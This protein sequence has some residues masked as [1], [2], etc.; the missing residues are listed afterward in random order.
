VLS[1]FSSREYRLLWAG[2]AI[3]FLGDQF[4]LVALPWLVL[5]LTRDPLQLGLVLACS[6]ILR[7]AF[8][9][10]G[11][12]WAD[13]HSPR[14]IMLISDAVR[15]LVAMLLFVTIMTGTIELWMIYVVA[16][17]FGT[18]SGFFHPAA[19]AAIPRLLDSKRLESGNS[20]FQLA[21]QVAAFLGP[22]AAGVLIAYFGGAAVGGEEVAS[23]RGIGVAFALDGAS[24]ALSAACLALMRPIR[25]ATHLDQDHPFA[26]IKEGLAWVWREPQIRMMLI[27]ITCASL[28]VSGPLIVGLP[29][30]ANERLIGGAAAFG[31][32]LSVFAGGNVLGMI[33]AGS[34]PR[35]DGKRFVFAAV[36]LIAGFGVAIGALAF[37]DATWQALPLMALVG[38]ANG[39]MAVTFISQLQR[40]TP[41][42]MLGRIMGLYM[43]SVYG[44]MPLSQAFAGVV[45]RFNINAVFIGAGACLV[46][47]A[48]LAASRPEL[49]ELAARL[50]AATMEVAPAEA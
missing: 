21:D 38:G 19:N 40:A 47:V 22:A 35:L 23:L 32:I 1:A 41:E 42:A 46:G 15:F 25:A 12:A 31:L 48:I 3:S 9:M 28:F 50:D 8:M 33:A 5:S 7:A 34:L 16:G 2:Q 44:L 30:L 10:I 45:A 24:F 4:H 13:H 29:V 14:A 49:R 17:V 6:G 37:V 39:Y 43:L 18:V 20:L 27:I 26:A 11:G 36:A